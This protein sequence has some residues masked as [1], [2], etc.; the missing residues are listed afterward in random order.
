M[1][2]FGMLKDGQK[3]SDIFFHTDITLVDGSILQDGG[4][5]SVPWYPDT[6]ETGAATRDLSW[7]IEICRALF[8]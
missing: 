3:M 7:F 6:P 2:T 5:P 8:P 1:S 4:W